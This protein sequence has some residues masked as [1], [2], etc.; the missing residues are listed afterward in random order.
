MAML[1]FNGC[2]NPFVTMGEP[3][4]TDFSEQPSV[5]MGEACPEDFPEQPSVRMGRVRITEDV[6]A[7]VAAENPDDLI[8]EDG[9]NS[10]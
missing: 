1:L 2:E 3:L 6:S 10:P 9:R 7:N 5:E 8:K 4:P